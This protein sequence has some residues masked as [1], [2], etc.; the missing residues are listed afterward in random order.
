MPRRNRVAVE[1]ENIASLPV[2]MLNSHLDFLFLSSLLKRLRALTHLPSVSVGVDPYPGTT[3]H[4]TFL[5]E[6]ELQSIHYFLSQK[7]LSLVHH[8]I[9][10]LQAIFPKDD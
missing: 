9:Q 6:S 4:Y 5:R 8:A 3:V 10:H 7:Y 1:M 2:K